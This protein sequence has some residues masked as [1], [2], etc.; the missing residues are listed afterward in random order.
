MK[1]HPLKQIGLDS[2][3]ENVQAEID[4][5]YVNERTLGVLTLFCYSKTC[6]IDYHW[7]D[8][9]KVCRGL[10]VNKKAKKIVALPFPK[11]FNYSELSPE[12]VPSG[13]FESHTKVD[14]S[15][16]IIYYAENVWRID[17]KGGFDTEVGVLAQKFFSDE[18]KKDNLNPRFTYLCEYCS[19]YNIVVTP[20]KESS[21]VFL[22][23]YDNGTMEEVNIPDA[24][25]SS[26]GFKLNTK[27]SFNS[28][29][30]VFD[31]CEK[32]PYHEEGF[33]LVWPDGFRVKV[34]GEEYKIAHKAVSN[35]TPKVVWEM[36]SETGSAQSLKTVLPEEFWPELDKME[37]DL[38]SQFNTLMS[39]IKELAKETGHLSDKELGLSLP[40]LPDYGSFLFCYRK[41][42]ERLEQQ[43]WK[44]LKP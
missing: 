3:L 35:F 22:G 29:Q 41:K 14:G 21:L 28:L 20:H 19:P 23:A 39:N 30:E 16:A 32:L 12:M 7:N 42:P 15:L 13:P 34:K 11:F 26:L 17:T 4:A 5:G 27:H 2:F 1:F 18:I 33:V 38:T 43:L 9:T 36:L 8:I 40:N 44:K 10:I 6:P 31:T 25:I 37:K 24:E